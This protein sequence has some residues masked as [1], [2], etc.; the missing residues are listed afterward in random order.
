MARKKEGK[1][2]KKYTILTVLGILAAFVI[3]TVFGPAFDQIITTFQNWKHEQKYADGL[4]FVPLDESVYGEGG[5]SDEKAVVAY[6]DTELHL[7]NLY[8]GK[9]VKTTIEVGNGSSYPTRLIFEPEGPVAVAVDEEKAGGSEVIIPPHKKGHIPII[10]TAPRESFD[11]PVLTLLKLNQEAVNGENLAQKM[12]PGATI[13]IYTPNIAPPL[14]PLSL[15]T[16]AEFNGLSEDERMLYELDKGTTYEDIA[17]DGFAKFKANVGYQ[18]AKL[19]FHTYGYINAM[20]IVLGVFIIIFIIYF[21]VRKVGK[22]KDEE[23]IFKEF[24][25][26]LEL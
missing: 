2:K 23:Q 21:I 19:M 7:D 25:E 20:L 16:K 18:Y 9:T 4:I 13:P 11:K 8:A 24:E 5:K 1:K 6:F 14:K 12:L 3:G 15:L 17:T 26:S 10:I 22:N